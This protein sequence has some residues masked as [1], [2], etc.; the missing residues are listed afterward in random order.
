MQRLKRQGVARKFSFTH[1]IAYALVQTARE[2]PFITYSFRRENGQA[3]RVEAG[4]FILKA[5]SR[6]REKKIWFTFSRRARY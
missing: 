6:Y 1:L 3:V 4:R 5:R 2:M